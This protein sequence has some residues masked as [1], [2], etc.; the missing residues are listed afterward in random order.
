[1]LDRAHNEHDIADE[2]GSRSAV[3][4]FPISVDI[5]GLAKRIGPSGT[6]VDIALDAARP[7]VDFQRTMT[8]H[9]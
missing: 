4:N 6:V 7:L 1:M 9:G 3:G 5:S 2:T 8:H